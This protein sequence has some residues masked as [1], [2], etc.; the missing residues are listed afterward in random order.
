[1]QVLH[2]ELAQQIMTWLVSKKLAPNE[3]LFP[4][5]AH[6]GGIERKTAKMMRRDLHAARK[7][8]LKYRR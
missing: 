5:S 7:A 3:L 4:I 6:S 1:V 2:P 8:W